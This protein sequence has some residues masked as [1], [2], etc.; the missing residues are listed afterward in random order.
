MIWQLAW[1]EWR[2]ARA[3]L[4]FWLLLA[5]TQLL[6]AWLLFAQ[7]EAFAR[8]A[9]Q[10]DTSGTRL[11][12]MD[13]VIAPTLG[14]LLLVMLFTTPLLAQGG[15]A[16]EQRSGRLP[17]WLSAPLGSTELVLGRI[18]GVFLCSLPLLLS[19][20]LTLALIGLGIGLDWPRLA[21]GIGMLMLFALWLSALVVGLSTLVDHPAAALAIAYSVV[22]FL[23]L[24]DSLLHADASWYW[25]ALLPHLETAFRGLLR[26]TDIVFF[27]ATGGAMAWLGIYRIARRR[28]DL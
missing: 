12:V 23:W 6:I 24:L 10:L 4:L 16:G 28:G 3:G 15:F 7:L 5:I 2:R 13:L 19:G 18:T 27:V 14:S 17:L 9:P 25:A 21:L 20:A 26:S 8:I 22:L 11:D 1:H